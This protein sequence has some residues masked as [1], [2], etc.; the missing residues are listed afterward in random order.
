LKIHKDRRRGSCVLRG[1]ILQK[2]FEGVAKIPTEGAFVLKRRCGGK[3]KR[4]MGEVKKIGMEVGR[5]GI[6]SLE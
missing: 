5:T 4:E 2:K 1:P 6:L 3:Q